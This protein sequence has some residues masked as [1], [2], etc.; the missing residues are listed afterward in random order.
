MISSKCSIFLP[1]KS[2]DHTTH[3]KKVLIPVKILNWYEQL[4]WERIIFVAL[5]KRRSVAQSQIIAG[6]HSGRWIMLTPC[7]GYGTVYS[8]AASIVSHS[9]MRLQL[10]SPKRRIYFHLLQEA[11]S[12]N[13]N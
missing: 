1:F 12:L 9:Y 3:S 6:S 7:C 2:Q 4:K 8:L 5:Q 13:Q 10:G 11:L